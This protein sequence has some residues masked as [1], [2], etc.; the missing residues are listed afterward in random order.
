M[1][2]QSATGM[3]QPYVALFIYRMLQM[4]LFK[5]HCMSWLHSSVMDYMMQCLHLNLF[6]FFTTVVQASD[7]AVYCDWHRH[8][9]GNSHYCWGLLELLAS[10]QWVHLCPCAVCL[11]HIL[12]AAVTWK[13]LMSLMRFSKLFLFPFTERDHIR[14]A[15]DDMTQELNVSLSWTI[16]N[17][18]YI[19]T[20]P[21]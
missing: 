20:Y 10:S 1:I 19:T 6:F 8:I 18:C 12:H 7:L 16:F 2:L 5:C 15:L 4:Y 14:I 13:N 21:L 9:N 17:T 3:T 11:F